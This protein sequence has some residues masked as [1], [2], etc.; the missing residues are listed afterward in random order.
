MSSLENFPDEV[1]ELIFGHLEFDSLLRLT[2][3]S[4]RMNEIIS[5][6][7]RIMAKI[8][9]IWNHGKDSSEVPAK[10]RKY[11]VLQVLYFFGC[12]AQLK[13]FFETF[14]DTL[15][16]IRFENCEIKMA[17]LYSLLS[18]VAPT[19]EYFDFEHA[20]LMEYE[21]L[22]PIEMP[23]LK[24]LKLHDLR[25][26]YNVE[27]FTSMISTCS[28]R[29]FQ[30]EDFLGRYRKPDAST[31]EEAAFLIDFITR[32]THLTCVFLRPSVLDAVIEYWLAQKQLTIK[33]EDL[34]I[35]Y[36]G[37]EKKFP[38][39]WKFLQSQRQSLKTLVVVWANFESEEVQ[40]LLSLDL[41]E[42]ELDFCDFKWNRSRATTNN[43]IEI[44][45]IHSYTYD[46]IGLMV[47]SCEALK[48][49]E[50]KFAVYHDMLLPAL[51]TIATSDSIT[52]LKI[53]FPF[54]D[55]FQALN[56]SELES[57]LKRKME[58]QA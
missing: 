19:L 44:L 2:E 14:S 41:K 58:W 6:S 48:H 17:D 38:V 13:K 9:V 54:G 43:S 30:Y 47:S 22:P 15:I 24:R 40:D 7:F 36:D 1:M 32:Q 16:T 28:L 33:L 23:K 26:G 52:S 10:H 4:P 18:M 56:H 27:V 3:T 12:S 57:A 53:F 8:Q 29:S 45:R 55:F 39:H 50:I 35:E 42:L 21:P 37:S 49:I 51:V 34:Y 46:S 20:A 5:N 31:R 25:D 11:R